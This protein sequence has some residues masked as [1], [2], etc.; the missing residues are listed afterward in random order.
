MLCVFKQQLEIEAACQPKPFISREADVLMQPP[1]V[2]QLTKK[3]PTEQVPFNLHSDD[4]LRDRRQ[5]NENIRAETERREKEIEEKRKVE[6]EQIR[7][8]IRKATTFKASP[9]PFA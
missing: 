8:E 4:R 1:F 3:L 5:F 6:D 2:P 7:R 9:N